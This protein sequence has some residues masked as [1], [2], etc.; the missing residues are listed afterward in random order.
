MPTYADE[1]PPCG[2]KCEGDKMGNH[3]FCE[4][5]VNIVRSYV[6]EHLDKSD[7]TP[8][9]DVFIVWSVKVLQNNKALVSTTLPD[10]MYY[11]V[12]HNG[13]NNETYLDA[14]KKFENRCF[15]HI[16]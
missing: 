3:E 6:L 11:E 7:T 13:D 16:Q 1:R 9:F 14:Y 4:S 8:D 5:A 10:G 15:K 12:T 2:R